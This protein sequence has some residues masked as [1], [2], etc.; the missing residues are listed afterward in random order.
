MSEVQSVGLPSGTL[1]VGDSGILS[2]TA[3]VSIPKPLDA[4][5]TILNAQATF[6]SSDLTE[7]LIRELGHIKSEVNMIRQQQQVL[8]EQLYELKS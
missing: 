7:K 3:G 1:G 5:S 6:D 4:R 8:Q 2:Y